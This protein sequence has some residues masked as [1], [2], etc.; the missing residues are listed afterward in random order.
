MITDSDPIASLGHRHA[1]NEYLTQ[2]SQYGL[3]GFLL[4]IS[5]ITI[6]LKNAKKIEDLWLSH[7][8][9]TGIIVFALNALTD[10]SLHNDWEGWAFVL[11]VSIA[12]INISLINP[13][14]NK[15]ITP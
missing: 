8:I 5:I 1:H 11:F 3:I 10:S 12:S 15:K 14:L 4:L 7:V 6:S 2:L 13:R 9:T